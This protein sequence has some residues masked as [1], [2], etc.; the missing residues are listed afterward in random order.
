MTKFVEER[1]EKILFSHPVTAVHI[2]ESNRPVES[3]LKKFVEVIKQVGIE[4]QDEIINVFLSSPSSKIQKKFE[5]LVK[6]DF[7]LL[8]DSKETLYPDNYCEPNPENPE[9]CEINFDKSGW[10]FE[11]ILIEQIK[12]LRLLYEADSFVGTKEVMLDAIV[13]SLRFSFWDHR[14]LAQTQLVEF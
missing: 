11:A 5:N 8:F 9:L 4:G 10:D 14:P 7:R 3:N 6:N 12:L 13:R 1:K 2:T